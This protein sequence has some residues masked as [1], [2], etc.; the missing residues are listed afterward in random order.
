MGALGAAIL[1]IFVS[2]FSDTDVEAHRWRILG[3]ALGA[4]AFEMILSYLLPGL[5]WALLILLV[6]VLLIALALVYWCGT[7]R[8]QAIKVTGIFTGVRLA[9]GIGIA[10]LWPPV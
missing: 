2:M 9:L 8:K 4:G 5:I 10:L 3:I 7:P 6:E 1:Y